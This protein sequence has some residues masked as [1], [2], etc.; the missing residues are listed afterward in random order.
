MRSPVDSK[1]LTS[2]DF[3]QKAAAAIAAGLTTFL[4]Q[5]S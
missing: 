3:R 5:K 4:T 1:L 2:A